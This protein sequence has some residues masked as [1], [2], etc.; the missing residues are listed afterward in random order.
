[1]TNKDIKINI[2]FEDDMRPTVS[3]VITFDDSDDMGTYLSL[4]K[5][6]W[7]KAVQD[8]IMAKEIL[9]RILTFCRLWVVHIPFRL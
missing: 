2:T 1:M 9:I 3:M 8:N 7:E 4:M 5:E 6:T